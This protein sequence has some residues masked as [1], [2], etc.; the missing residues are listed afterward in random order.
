[1]VKTKKKLK[2]ILMIRIMLNGNVDLASVW[3]G[4]CHESIIRPDQELLTLDD[5]LYIFS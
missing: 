2:S 1:M 4:D 5:Y 3:L